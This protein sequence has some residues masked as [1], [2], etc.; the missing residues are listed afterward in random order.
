M[1]RHLDRRWQVPN[2]A[3]GLTDDCFA[4]VSL[5]GQCPEWVGWNRSITWTDLPLT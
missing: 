4:E 3:Y 1:T 5:V 2:C